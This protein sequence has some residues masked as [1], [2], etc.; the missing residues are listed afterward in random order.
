MFDV[1]QNIKIDNHLKK[2]IT[3]PSWNFSE[4]RMSCSCGDLLHLKYLNFYLLYLKDMDSHL[5]HPKYF[6]Q[7]LYLYFLYLKYLHLYLYMFWEYPLFLS[8]LLS[9]RTGWEYFSQYSFQVKQR[10][11]FFQYVWC[12]AFKLWFRAE[13]YLK[14][15]N[16]NISNFW[17]L[18]WDLEI[19]DQ[20]FESRADWIFDL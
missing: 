19:K 12:H 2:P 15:D 3:C 18:I 6:H 16:K 11:W 5:L 4:A 20:I 14:I 8:T 9:S 10:V 7:D 1:E 13:H 17:H